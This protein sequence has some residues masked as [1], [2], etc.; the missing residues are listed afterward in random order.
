MSALQHQVFI[1]RFT[2]LFNEPN[3]SIADEI[4][5]PGFKSHVPLAPE[6]DREGWKAY[7]QN[8]LTGFPDL[9]MDVHESIVT[10]DRV[11]LRVTYRGTHTGVFQGVPASGK[12]IAM[13]AIGF[14]HIENGMGMENWAAFDVLGLMMQIGAIPAPTS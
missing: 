11:V 5:A 10:P 13:P 8:F 12:P 4:L 14:F 3:L 1:Q 7:V 2:A 9:N 6:V